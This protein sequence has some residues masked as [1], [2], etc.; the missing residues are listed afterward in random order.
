MLL[1]GLRLAS[2]VPGAELKPVVESEEDVYTYTNANNGSGPMW[3]H[4]STSLVR[5]GNRVFASGLELIP[6]VKPMNNRRW[7]LFERN[8]SGWNRVWVD[9][10]GRTREPSPLAAFR[11]GR[12][13]VST[14]P[15]LGPG[16]ETNGYP[17]RPDL[18]EFKAGDEGL[19]AGPK[20]YLTWLRF[21]W[22]E[23][24]ATRRAEGD[25]RKLLRWG[26]FPVQCR[27]DLSD[28]FQRQE[29]V[30]PRSRSDG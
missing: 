28:R 10:E 18:L 3:C 15:S 12:V 23:P 26:R 17:A 27:Q 29:A 19:A 13:F 6:G 8:A 30:P 11:N 25:L 16:D 2:G 22:C 9:T 21:V 4:G 7:M 1:T 14:N 24:G 20:R 5:V